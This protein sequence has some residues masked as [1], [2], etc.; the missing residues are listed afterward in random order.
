MTMKVKLRQVNRGTISS[1]DIITAYQEA[2]NI[3][4]WRIAIDYLMRI[5]HLGGIFQ[6][7]DQYYQEADEALIK[8]ILDEDK[9]NLEQYIAEDFD[10]DDFT[11]RL[12]GVFHCD[13]RTAAMPIFI[14]WVVTSQGGHAVISYYHKSE[15]HIIEPQ[16]DWIY[17]V[18]SDWKLM[19]LCG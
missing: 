15:V 1:D 6:M 19:L 13:P 2:F 16:K 7:A 8:E 12:M 4:W 17:D 3:P 10:C 9:T 5:F 11:F 14:T 18:P